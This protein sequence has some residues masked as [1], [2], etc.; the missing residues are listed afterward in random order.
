VTVTFAHAEHKLSTVV[1]P[2]SFTAY[3]M[4][5]WSL[6]LPPEGWWW[7]VRQDPGITIWMD[8]LYRRTA[9]IGQQLALIVRAVQQ[10]E[11]S[12][13]ST[14]AQRDLCMDPDDHR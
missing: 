10:P 8:P 2:A 5:E 12:D 7:L 3:V 13:Q 14:T 6:P 9:K 1:F 4:K 11:L